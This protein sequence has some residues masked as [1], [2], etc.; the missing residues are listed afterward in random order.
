MLIDCEIDTKNYP[1]ILD[2]EVV[3][4]IGR[5]VKLLKKFPDDISNQFYIIFR[6]C[7]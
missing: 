1:F 7:F 4:A 5:D 3:F 6:I 2:N